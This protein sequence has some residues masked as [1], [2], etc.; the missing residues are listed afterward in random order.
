MVVGKPIVGSGGGKD[1]D[2][3]RAF[4]SERKVSTGGIERIARC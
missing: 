3:D 4:F 1:T 2:V